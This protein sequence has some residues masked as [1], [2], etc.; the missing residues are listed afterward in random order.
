[1]NNL[2]FQI[3]DAFLWMYLLKQ[4]FTLTVSQ[5]DIPVSITLIAIVALK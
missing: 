4:L 2:L 3:I 1:M 5:S